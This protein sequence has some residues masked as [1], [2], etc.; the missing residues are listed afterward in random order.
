[1][2]KEQ[3][4]TFAGNLID[5]QRFLPGQM[6]LTEDT[7]N[8]IEYS[9]A[10]T[11]ANGL[12]FEFEANRDESDV[13]IVR[14][15]LNGAEEWVKEYVT[16]NSDYADGYH[17]IVHETR[18]EW[19]G[20]VEDYLD[21]EFGNADDFDK[22]VEYVVD[23]LDDDDYEAEYNSSDYGKY[24]GDGCSLW[25]FKI[26]EYEEQIDVTCFDGIHELHNQG[27]L[28]DVLDQLDREF[29]I[30]R[31]RRREKNKET[32]HYE[33]VGRATYGA[34]SEY[35][36]FEIYTYPGGGWDF[37][38]SKERMDELVAE[39]ISTRTLWTE[40]DEDRSDWE[41]DG[42]DVDAM[43]ADYA[44]GTFRMADVEK[45]NLENE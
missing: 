40:H 29:C 15:E 6:V 30:H 26:E 4:M 16:E 7:Q 9:K 33:P 43:E 42:Y 3:Q 31:S 34:D 27:R 8:E 38:V 37:V 11:D 23:N 20:I 39:Y 19:N 45:Y 13:A 2:T 12:P 32:G 24:N 17:H 10:F 36:T 44:N 41:I 28:D 22:L 25:G 18:Q 14:D 21:T 35:P 5:V 1:M